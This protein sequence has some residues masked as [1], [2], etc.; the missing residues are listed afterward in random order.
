MEYFTELF[1]LAAELL[2]VAFGALVQTLRVMQQLLNL[3]HLPLAASQ[4]A[5]QLLYLPPQ[6][7][8]LRLRGGG[9]RW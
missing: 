6:L 9:W 3:P 2:V 5:F 7:G 8:Q 1:Y 4:L